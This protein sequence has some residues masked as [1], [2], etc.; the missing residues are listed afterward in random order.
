MTSTSTWEID[1]SPVTCGEPASRTDNIDVFHNIRARDGVWDKKV[2]VVVVVVNSR[3][4]C[5]I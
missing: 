5:A 3:E 2:V 4:R 1:E